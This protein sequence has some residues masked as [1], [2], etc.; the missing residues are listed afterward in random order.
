MFCTFEG[1]LNN[2]ALYIFHSEKFDG[3]WKAHENNPVKYDVRSSR[4]GGTPFLKDGKLFRPAQDCSSS[5]GSAIVISEIIE[6][7]EKTFVEKSIKRI[8]PKPNWKFNKG[9]HTFSIV[10]KDKVLIDAK[11]YTFNFDNFNHAMSRKIKRIFGK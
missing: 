3:E 9:L 7:T 11:R 10:G 2:T 6:L 1:N 5:Y 4:P 8:E